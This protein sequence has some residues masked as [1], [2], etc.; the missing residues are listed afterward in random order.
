MYDWDSTARTIEWIYYGG[1]Q[2]PSEKKL[3]ALKKSATEQGTAAVES[4]DDAT[5]VELKKADLQLHFGILN[6]AKAF[7]IDALLQNERSNIF[8]IMSD[9]SDIPMLVTYLGL[10]HKVASDDELMSFGASKVSERLDELI[11][12]PDF[13]SLWLPGSFYKTILDRCSLKNGSPDILTDTVNRNEQKEQQTTRKTAFYDSLVNLNV[14]NVANNKPRR[15]LGK[16]LQPSFGLTA[17]SGRHIYFGL[18]QHRTFFAV[19]KSKDNIGHDAPKG[20]SMARSGAQ[21]HEQRTR[22]SR[23]LDSNGFQRRFLQCQKEAT[24]IAQGN[25]QLSSHQAGVKN[26]VPKVNPVPVPLSDCG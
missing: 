15:L 13:E 4:L 14:I 25:D 21:P 22:S 26:D 17:I 7:Q 11:G 10:L 23:V 12:N 18:R 3:E 6:I 24:T 8:S 2:T 9:A 20:I 16:K 5:A 1:Y 19:S